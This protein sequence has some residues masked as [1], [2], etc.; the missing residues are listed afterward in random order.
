MR[1]VIILM[2]LAVNHPKGTKNES[3]SQHETVDA[4]IVKAVNHPKGTK[5]ESNSQLWSM[6][7]AA[8]SAVNHPK[9]TKNESNSQHEPDSRKAR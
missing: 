7:I 4:E 3:N 9:G 1:K 2:M 5:N 8:R 6:T